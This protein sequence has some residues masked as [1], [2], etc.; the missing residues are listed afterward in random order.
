M[1]DKDQP[2][3]FDPSDLP[4]A[5]AKTGGHM[6]QTAP[7]PFVDQT[8]GHTDHMK[9]TSSERFDTGKVSILSLPRSGEALEMKDDMGEAA[10]SDE[11][12]YESKRVQVEGELHAGGIPGVPLL[13]FNVEAD[14][15]AQSR[16]E[17]FGQLARMRNTISDGLLEL[18][19][20]TTEIIENQEEHA[21]TVAIEEVAR[22]LNIFLRGNGRLGA[23][24]RHAYEEALSTVRAV[25]YASTLWAS[26][27]RSGEYSG[28]NIVHQIGIGAAKDARLRSRDW[29]VK[30]DGHVNELKADPGLEPAARS[31]EQVRAVAE[32]SRRAF[33][34]GA[35]RTAMEV[36]REPLTQAAVWSRCA[37]E[38]GNGPGFKERVVQ[39]LRN[40]FDEKHPEL[41]E[42]LDTR[43]DALWQ[44]SVIS[45]LMQLA[46]EQEPDARFGPDTENVGEFS[47]TT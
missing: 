13:F 15:A 39:H 23:R 17:L 18:C 35:Q 3:L 38:W 10:F 26:T 40:W 44:R 11:E 45:P 33:L 20:A 28:L 25:R 32:S 9:Q 42:T 43:L 4:P 30:I 41:Q 21:I 47:S 6:I 16:R 22:R 37:S 46:E 1:K 8:Q 36:Y 5:C 24:K 34:A 19:A 14:D 31:V 2:P 12:G 29:F 27:R 7:I